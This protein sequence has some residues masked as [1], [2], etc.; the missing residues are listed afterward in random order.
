MTLACSV[1]ACGLAPRCCSLGLRIGMS[2]C[3]V[4]SPCFYGGT[5]C[6]QLLYLRERQPP[7]SL[8]TAILDGARLL[9]SALAP[10]RSAA[11]CTCALQ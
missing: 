2:S 6:L 7:V 9:L 11:V 3:E 8:L 1:Q 5:P 10:A 4:A